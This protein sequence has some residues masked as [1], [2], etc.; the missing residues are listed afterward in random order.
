VKKIR[1][2]LVEDDV[3]SA[4]IARL[5]LEEGWEK[6]GVDA[7][8]YVCSNGEEAVAYLS[9]V[10]PLPDLIITDIK[11]PRM[12]GTQLLGVLKAAERYR[13]IPVVMLS[14]SANP[15]DV[16]K[17]FLGQCAGYIVKSIDLD[18]F[19]AAVEA[20]QR[21]WNISKLP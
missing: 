14:T 1:F 15:A 11:M 13:Q 2:L 5:A 18:A 8:V 9:T 4:L 17:A 3:S 6:Q 16:R 12:D 7:E 20:I 10:S 21:Y 19:Y